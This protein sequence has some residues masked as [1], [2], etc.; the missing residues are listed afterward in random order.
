MWHYW[1]NKRNTYVNK[2]QLKGKTIFN[3]DSIDEWNLIQAIVE[4]NK[5]NKVSQMILVI[6][7]LGE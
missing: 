3:F 1:E 4:Y 7:H 2:I 5:Q 6:K